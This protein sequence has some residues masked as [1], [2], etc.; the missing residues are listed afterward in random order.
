M[1]DGTLGGAETSI[2]AVLTSVLIIF[3]TDPVLIEKDILQVLARYFS[4]I[5]FSS[6]L[7]DS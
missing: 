1:V 3:A 2:H 4:K 6:L 7:Y 5:N